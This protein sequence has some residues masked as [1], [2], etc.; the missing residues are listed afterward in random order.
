LFNLAAQSFVGTSFEQPLF[1]SEVDAIGPLRILEAIRSMRLETRFYQASTSEMFGKVAE[2]PQ[3]ETTSLHPR[4]PYGV[5]K[6]F[7]HYITR[8]YREAYGMHA[9]SGILF[10]H[11]SPLRG[12]EFVTRKITIGLAKIANGSQEVLSLGNLDAQRDW[13]HARDFVR[14]MWLITD[15]AAGGE[16]VIATGKTTAVREF[17]NLA[18]TIAGFDLQFEG[19][20]VN[21]VGRDKKSGQTIVR[22]DAAFFRPAE[23][24]VLLGDATRARDL[25]GWE[26]AISL[27]ELAQEMVEADI[28]RLRTN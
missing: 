1:T 16:F 28:R 21:E 19:E 23:V 25:L 4:S 6:V 11:E 17:V 7:A 20:G 8:N 26:P 2:S 3:R 14:A 24:D 22:V 27:E 13:G 15:Q 5:A 10:N 18:G 12:Q 9:S